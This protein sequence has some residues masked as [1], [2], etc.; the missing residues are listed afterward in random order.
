ME[1]KIYEAVNWNTPENDYVE[2]FWEQNLRQFWID[3]EYIP[4]RDVDSWNGLTDEMKLAYMHV[5]GGLTLLDT[6]QSHTGMPKIIDHIKSLQNRSVL[7]YMTMMES[8]HAKSYS[9]IFTSVATTRE[10]NETFRWVQENPHLQYKAN[11]IDNYYQKMNNPE[12]SQRDVAM[13]LAASVF[14]ETYLFYSGFFL[15][16]WL[17]GQGEMVASCDIIKKIIADESIHGVF[18]GLLFQDLYNSFEKEMQDGMKKELKEL[19]YDLYENEAKYTDEIYGELSL[20]GDVKEYV[21]YNANKALMNLGFE[22]EFEI[23]EVNPIVLNGLNVETTQH[24]F[25]SKKSTNY[26]K[27]LE[28]VHLHDEDFKINENPEDLI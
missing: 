16:L 4:S 11:K 23:K 10:I 17:A 28:V 19:M 21:K 3:T 9:T 20:T 27:A 2:M 7:S 12:A 24:D 8:I 15:P 1:K 18:V 26:E 22:E 25:F 13:A 14:L 5:L 6:L